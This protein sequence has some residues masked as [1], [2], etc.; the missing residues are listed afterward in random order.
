[1]ETGGVYL[2]DNGYIL[3]L[4]FKFGVHGQLVNSLFGVEDLYKV[5]PPLF[6]DQIF[7]EPDALKQRIINII[8]YIRGYL[9]F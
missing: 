9:I 3:I 2:I 8:D 1:M 5:N 6:E 4:Y 7:S